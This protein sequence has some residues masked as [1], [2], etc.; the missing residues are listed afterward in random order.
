MKEK[1]KAE[2]G[3][4]PYRKNFRRWRASHRPTDE[5]SGC[6]SSFFDNFLV[7]FPHFGHS[8]S[9]FSTPLTRHYISQY[10][11]A[12]V[13]K[14]WAS[15]EFFFSR[16]SSNLYVVKHGFSPTKKA[17]RLRP[18]KYT[19]G[20]FRYPRVP[21]FL[22]F[23]VAGFVFSVATRRGETYRGVLVPFCLVF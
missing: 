8:T 2:G 14:F 11:N 7:K 22:S 18:R 17:W 4:P 16:R 20:V 12:L 1:R 15:V 23:S 9:V 13:K 3:F 5:K 10:I 21:R 6:S 19:T